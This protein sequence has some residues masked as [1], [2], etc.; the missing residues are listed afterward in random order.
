MK[1]T[2]LG[3]SQMKAIEFGLDTEDLLI[4]RWFIDFKGTD[5]MTTIKENADVYY[6]INYSKILEDI[7]ILNVTKERIK[8]KHFNKLCECGVLKHKYINNGGSYSYYSLGENYLSLIEDLGGRSKMTEGVGQ[9][10]PRG[11]VKNDLPNIDILNNKS[12]NNNNISSSSCNNID[13]Y[14]FLEQNGFRLS[15]IHYEV[16]ETWEDNE[17]TRYAIKKAVLNG[18]YNINY[19]DKILFNWQKDNITTVEQAKA[20]D[21]EFEKQKEFREKIKNER[22]MSFSDK[23]DMWSKEMEEEEND[24]RTSK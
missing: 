19:I 14:T 6:W 2:I 8:K 5:K 15:P 20:L 21:D 10:E 16:I 11:C 4:L 1:Y 7:P 12:I 18:K 3:F 9:K 24:K 17:L 13:I 23:I 22:K